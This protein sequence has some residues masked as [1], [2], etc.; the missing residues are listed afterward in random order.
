[1]IEL[2]L[3][4]HAKSDWYSHTSD[5]DRPLNS[6]G[7]DDAVAMGAFLANKDLVPN[8]MIISPAR[9]T[10]QTAELLLKNLPV[11]KQQVLIDRDLYLADMESISELIE[12]Y[13]A[14]EQRILLLAHNPGMD[15][16]VSYLADS[17]PPL[18]AN[19]KLMTTCAVAHF[20]L[21]SVN[22]SRKHGS[23]ELLGLYRPKEI[24]I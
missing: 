21:A 22:T 12:L 23:A 2:M 10:Q 14:D 15:D 19:G 9:R 8:K 4:R 5:I 20:V 17:T 24:T 7:R 1:M 13:A 18:S 11:D 6:R 3:M 16:M